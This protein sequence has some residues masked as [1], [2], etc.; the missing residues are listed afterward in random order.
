MK[1]CRRWA[2]VPSWKRFQPPSPP[3][4]PYHHSRCLPQLTLLRT[5][6]EPHLLFSSSSLHPIQL[7]NQPNFG[8]FDDAILFDW[9]RCPWMPVSYLSQC[10]V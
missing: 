3:P 10:A 8:L 7:F 5:K 1:S 9:L 4:Q 6:C 2:W